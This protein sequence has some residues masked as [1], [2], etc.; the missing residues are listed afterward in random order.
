MAASVAIALLHAVAWGDA[1]NLLNYQ[2]KLTDPSGSPK[3]GTFSMTFAVYDAASGGNQLPNGTPWSETQNVTVTNGVFNVLLGSA[4]A[5]PSDMFTGGPSDASGPLRF[6]Q[7]TVSGEALTPRSR[8]ASAAYARNT[9]YA[10]GGTHVTG[11]TG[12]GISISGTNTFSDDNGLITLTLSAPARVLL[13]FTG[14]LGFSSTVQ[15]YNCSSSFNVDSGAALIGNVSH[16][17]FPPNNQT[18]SIPASGTVFTGVLSA[19]AHTFR[20]RINVGG[21]PYSC[22]LSG[23]LYAVALH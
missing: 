4:T 18:G 16:T 11:S 5:L 7:V 20:M 15:S 6:W 9:G 17:P 13:S 19:G 2:G 1:P 8:I 10:P 23:T 14:N 21:G 22:S 3:N 12:V